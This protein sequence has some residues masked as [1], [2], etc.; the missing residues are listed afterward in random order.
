MNEITPLDSSR[1]PSSAPV[2]WH[3]T[4]TALLPSG[5]YRLLPPEQTGCITEP[6]RARN[7]DQVFFTCTKAYA[8][9]YA[10]RAARRYGGQPVIY[11]VIPVG[12]PACI[13]E[14]N[15]CEVYHAPFAFI[16]AI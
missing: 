15:G 3:G 16:E 4:T 2:Y 8:G 14:A 10:M 6:D 11:R 5:S 7:L 1:H 13:N 9:I 12:A